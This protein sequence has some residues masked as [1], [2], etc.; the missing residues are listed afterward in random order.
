MVTQKVSEPVQDAVKAYLELA[1]G[2]TEASKKKAEKTV[3]K[4]AKELAGKGGATASQLQG[5]AEELVA[6]GMANREAVSRL[7]RVE[8]D[9]ALSRVGLAT[10]DEVATLT[11]R[12]EALER[13]LRDA[14]AAAPLA[15]PAAAKKTTAPAKKAPAVAKKTAAAAEKP[16]AKAVDVPPVAKK[17]VAKKTVAK[18]A[19]AKKATP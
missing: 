8:M 5:M 12:I 6:T 18:K 9:R 17:A 19:V 15:E 1:F 3:K 14:K 10:A 16:V 2:L 4:L 11:S 13:Q 7:V